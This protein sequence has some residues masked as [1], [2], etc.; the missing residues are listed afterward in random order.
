M[1]AGSLVGVGL[2]VWFVHLLGQGQAII[3]TDEDAA[4]LAE[5]L[6][7]GFNAG[8]VL[9]DKQGRAALVAD[10]GG[11]GFVLMKQAGSH[12]SGRFLQSP[13]IEKGTD[14]LK[15]ESDDR[16]FGAVTIT[17]ANDSIASQFQALTKRSGAGV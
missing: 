16:W 8:M 12:A 15:I 14:G 11:Q 10:A 3:E 1:L 7:P 6:A 17:P 4:E 9:R 13:K 2:V 5:A